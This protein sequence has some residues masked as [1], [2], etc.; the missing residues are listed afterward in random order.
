MLRSGFCSAGWWVCALLVLT[1]VGGCSRSPSSQA[2]F[3]GDEPAGTTLPPVGGARLNPAIAG[4]QADWVEFRQPPSPEEMAAEPNE[5]QPSPATDSGEDWNAGLRT[6]VEDYN[7]LVAEG[8][9]DGLLEYFVAEQEDV[10]RPLLTAALSLSRKLEQ[11]CQAAKAAAQEAPGN[12]IAERCTRAATMFSPQLNVQ[13][14]RRTEPAS[15]AMQVSSRVFPAEVLAVQVDEEWYF[16]LGDTSGLDAIPTQLDALAQQVEQWTEGISAGT[17]TAADIAANL[18]Q[19][20]GQS[21]NSPAAA[22]N[23]PN[24]DG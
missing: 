1:A 16:Q 7:G 15:A 18:D 3:A 17:T 14:Y 8:D 11:L 6:V 10:L 9:V 13:E 24:S 2:D 22:E 23:T 12:D 20:L 21:A 19:A 5:P 4:G